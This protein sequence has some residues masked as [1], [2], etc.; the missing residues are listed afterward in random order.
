MELGMLI[1]PARG[2]EHTIVQFDRC[3]EELR[4]DYFWLPDRLLIHNI[5]HVYRYLGESYDERPLEL[6]DPFITISALAK[7]AATPVHFGIAVT[8]FIR[9]GPA[10]L[11]RAA[12]T[13]SQLMGAPLQMGFGAGETLNLVPFGYRHGASPV[14]FLEEQLQIFRR[15]NEDGVYCAQGRPEVRLGYNKIP[16]KIWVGGQRERMLKI[17][18]R[19]ADGWLPAWKMK[20]AEYGEKCVALRG[21]AQQEGRNCPTLGMFAVPRLGKSRQAVFDYF[22]D[23]P[24]ARSIALESPAELWRT[25]GLKHPCGEDSKGIY[26]ELLSDI[27][28]D[29]LYQALLTVP[30]EFIDTFCFAGNAE[31]LLEEF[32]EYRQAGMQHLA[33]FMPYFAGAPVAYGIDGDEM[34]RQLRLICAEVKRW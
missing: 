11:A 20:P 33:L 26:D 2:L 19:C 5:A 16:S 13:L 23:R 8:E 4:P 9:R 10:D 6:L 34:H 22:R 17:T 14:S 21:L 30:P 1:V 28:P 18:A 12:D 29:V 31:E 7:R 24:L 25:W 32:W 27:A 15:I 3:M